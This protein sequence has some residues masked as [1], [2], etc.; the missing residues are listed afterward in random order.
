MQVIVRLGHFYL[1]LSSNRFQALVKES[2]EKRK[3][4][5]VELRINLT[6]CMSAAQNSLLEIG[7]YLF[8][9]LKRLNVGLDMDDIS[10]E[11]IYSQHFHRSLQCKLDPMW[12]QLSKVSFL[13]RYP[14]KSSLLNQAFS[15]RNLS[16]G[17]TSKSLR[18]L[19]FCLVV[20]FYSDVE[21]A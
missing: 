21:T 9:E 5:V 15:V 13:D 20:F 8:K 1:L 18:L 16:K 7:A 10:V 6:S 2:L 3:P 12:H 4:S 17:L 19:K 11:S 14:S